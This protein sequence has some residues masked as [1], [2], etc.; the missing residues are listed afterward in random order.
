MI[1]QVIPGGGEGHPIVISKSGLSI[2]GFALARV[3]AERRAAVAMRKCIVLVAGAGVVRNIR[4]EE[5]EVS[6]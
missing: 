3:A 1:L 5:V 4:K 2:S 6:G